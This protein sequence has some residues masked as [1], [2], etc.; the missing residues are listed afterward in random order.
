MI[1]SFSLLI[2]IVPLMSLAQQEPHFSSDG[3]S[4]FW[5]NPASTGALQKL[6]VTAVGRLH[7]VGIDSAP[8]SIMVNTGYSFDVNGKRDEN[9]KGKIGVG[10]NLM[11]EKVGYQN[12]W[13]FQVPLNYQFDL[14]ETYLSVGIAP[15]FKQINFSPGSPPSNPGTGPVIPAA[16]AGRFFNLDAG[17]FWYSDKFYLGLSSTQL[18]EPSSVGFQ[19]A[20]HYHFQAA[21]RFS[22]GEHY[23]YP[24]LQVIADGASIAFWNLNYFQFKDDIFSVGA[25]IGG[26][27]DI[28]LA[29][30]FRYENF[31]IAY[32]FDWHT[33]LL[34]AYT[35]GSHEFRLSYQIPNK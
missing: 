30:T 5:Q 29:A 1:K 35:N 14:K 22:L 31:K 6:S 3:F 24:Q 9:S 12:N 4:S 26:G 7:W 34:S 13:T 17:V 11:K 32:N 10:I 18:A 23:I 28:L 2:F 16:I 15:G 25:G 27:R 8:K 20:R 33:G 19:A 21:Y